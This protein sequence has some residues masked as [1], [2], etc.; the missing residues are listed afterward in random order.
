MLYNGL[1]RSHINDHNCRVKN[2]EL[3]R[4]VSFKCILAP[5][6][7]DSLCGAS[8]LVVR[9]VM[10]IVKGV[11]CVVVLG[12]RV[13]CLWGLSHSMACSRLLTITH[14]PPPFLDQL[15]APRSQ[16]S[17]LLCE[18][19]KHQLGPQ[20]PVQPSYVMTTMNCFTHLPYT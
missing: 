11:T 13:Q 8:S 12:S 10:V 14:L 1:S 3:G 4:R 15:A 5:R 16:Q 18:M 20:K 6:Q 7:N 19:R 9:E 2:D 17:R